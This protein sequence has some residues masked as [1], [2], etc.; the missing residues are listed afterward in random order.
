MGVKSTKIPNN[1]KELEGEKEQIWRRQLSQGCQSYDAEI[2]MMAPCVVTPP[3]M[4]V[5][6]NT[7]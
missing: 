6:A 4:P 7:C 1:L 2:M 3:M 5:M